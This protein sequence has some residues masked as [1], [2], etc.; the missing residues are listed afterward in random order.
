[1][2]HIH[3]VIIE[4]DDPDLVAHL[5]RGNVGVLPFDTIWGL[6]ACLQPEAIQRLYEIKQRDR[7]QPFLVVAK[8][9][10][11]AISMVTPLS[12]A[13]QNVLAAVWPGPVTCILNKSRNV[14]DRV[15]ADLP[16]VA[17][18][19]PDPTTPVYRL[20]EQLDQPLVSTS[21][22]FS[23]QPSPSCFDDLDPE[24]V[25][26]LDFVVQ[27]THHTPRLQSTIVDLSKQPFWVVRPG[28]NVDAVE[29]V[30]DSISFSD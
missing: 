27:D 10:D 3:E 30:L 1:M 18:R 6:G 11:V 12:A 16:T 8:S 23:G 7:R 24:L 28:A 20:L 22:N 2:K 26:Q 9:M 29:S 25:Q 4:W 14:S 13:Q 19:V 17:I 21:A 15:T 5:L